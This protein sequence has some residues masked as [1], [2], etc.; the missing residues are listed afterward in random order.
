MSPSSK[1]DGNMDNHAAD[2]DLKTNAG[3]NVFE[4]LLADTDVIIDGYSP[5]ALDKLG[6]GSA[7]FAELAKARGK[8]IVYV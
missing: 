1:F 5:G 2:L 6:Y 4:Q 8:G 7:K 3:R